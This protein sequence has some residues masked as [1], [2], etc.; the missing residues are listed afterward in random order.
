MF[1]LEYENI[2]GGL[3][4]TYFGVEWNPFKHVGFGLGYNSVTYRVE[5]DGT[6]SN[7]L[8][9]NCKINL[10]LSGLLLYARY[11]F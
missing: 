6:A 9:Y 1:Y 8:D 4:D 5:R 3:A 11:F 7:G 2:T 10:E